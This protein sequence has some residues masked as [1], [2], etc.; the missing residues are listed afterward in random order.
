MDFSIVE[1]AFRDTGPVTLSCF[2]ND[3]LLASLHCRR[4]GDYHIEKPVP[5]SWLGGTGP[6]VVRAVLDKVWVAPADGTRL[7]YVLPRAGIRG[8]PD[9]E[10]E[11]K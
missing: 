8:K 10:G 9:R 1:T 3:H 6:T 4:P 11:P 5:S 7:G 2:V